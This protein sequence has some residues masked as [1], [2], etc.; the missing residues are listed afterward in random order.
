M[1]HIFNIVNNFDATSEFRAI[2]PYIPIWRLD[3]AMSYRYDIDRFLCAKSFLLLEDMLRQNFGMDC[4]PEFTY[5]DNGKPYFREH[6]DICFSISHCHRGIACAVMDRPVGIDI[7]D[8]QYDDNLAKIILNPEELA[9][10]RSADEPD[11]RF[12]E[13]W[14]KKES[15][16]KLTGEGLRDNMKD[17]L[18]DTNEVSLATEINRPAGYVYSIAYEKPACRDN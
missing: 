13:F 1:I 9:I 3:K 18:S 4:C 2:M 6:P 12:T 10:V 7:E 17:V 5:G 14:T 16:L 8:I 15:F 11:V